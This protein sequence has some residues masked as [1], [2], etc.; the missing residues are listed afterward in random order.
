M[1]YQNWILPTFDSLFLLIVSHLLLVI[2]NYKMKKLW[3]HESIFPYSFTIKTG[4]FGDHYF[5]T[6]TVIHITTVFVE[7][8]ILLKELGPIQLYWKSATL[9]VMERAQYSQGSWFRTIFILKCVSRKVIVLRIFI[10]KG[11]CS[12]KINYQEALFGILEW[13]LVRK[14]FL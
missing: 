9:I 10:T 5:L 4:N 3:T 1:K 14:T 8:T 2:W 11:D 13:H 12:K 6:L 7:P